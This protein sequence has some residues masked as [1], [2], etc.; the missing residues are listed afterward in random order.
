ML[1][2]FVES[3]QNFSHLLG[4]VGNGIQANHR[5]PCA[6]GKA[7]QGGGGN[8]LRVVGGVIRLQAAGQSAGQADGGVAMGGD[9]NFCRRVDE[10]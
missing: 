4:G 9:G 3:P 1:F 10:V 7:L 2:D 6:E 5:I 8:A